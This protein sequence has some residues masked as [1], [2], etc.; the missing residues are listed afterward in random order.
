MDG[1]ISRENI[2][3]LEISTKKLPPTETKFE[4]G[5]F[6]IFETEFKLY[7]SKAESFSLEF[8]A[9]SPFSKNSRF[10]FL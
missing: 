1:F 7:G 2:D 9:N 6:F 5:I 10:S 8:E 3:D 4:S